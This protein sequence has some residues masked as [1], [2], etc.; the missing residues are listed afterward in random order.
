LCQVFFH[1]LASPFAGA[2]GDGALQIQ[3]LCLLSSPFAGAAGVGALQIVRGVI[4]FGAM[5][6]FDAELEAV[7]NFAELVGDQL[8]PPVLPLTASPEEEEDV[9]APARPL[10]AAE[11][12]PAELLVWTLFMLR[13]CVHPALTAR[14]RCRRKGPDL[15]RL[16]EAASGHRC[17]MEFDRWVRKDAR[18]F[19]QGALAAAV[20]AKVSHVKEEAGRLWAAAPAAVID[21]WCALHALVGRRWRSTLERYMKLDV[22]R[23]VSVCGYGFLAD[24]FHRF[25][26]GVAALPRLDR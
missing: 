25:A 6:E 17:D 10:I 26:S 24:V 11:A 14:R 7:F 2:A 20:G 21:R 12:S 1:L 16:A 13:R 4:G 9:V 23:R 18:W 22:V 19:F 5:D 3:C 8:L 15:R